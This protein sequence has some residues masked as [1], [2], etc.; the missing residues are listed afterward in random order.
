MTKS[1]NKFNQDYLKSIPIDFD[2]MLID[3]ENNMQLLLFKN[4]SSNKLFCCYVDET[5][6]EGV[7]YCSVFFYEN[8]LHIY[9]RFGLGQRDSFSE[10]YRKTF[11][12]SKC[13][14]D[15][16]VCHICYDDSSFYF[17]TETIYNFDE[18]CNL[19]KQS[20]I[21]FNRIGIETYSKYHRKL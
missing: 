8:I 18:F 1:L 14:N 7:I 19:S 17:D 20:K 4:K 12:C 6:P 3:C 15:N 9:D 2:K 5:S 16:M 11:D 21:I 13:G 10:T